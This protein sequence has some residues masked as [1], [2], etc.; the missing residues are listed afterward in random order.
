MKLSCQ[1]VSHSVPPDVSWDDYRYYVDRRR[2][3]LANQCQRSMS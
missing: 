1:P 2:K 3:L